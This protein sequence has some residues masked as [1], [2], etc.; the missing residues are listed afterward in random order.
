M[1]ISI[2]LIVNLYTIAQFC[3]QRFLWN[4]IRTKCCASGP[5]ATTISLL[6]PGSIKISLRRLA[7]LMYSYAPAT[8]AATDVEV[9]DP[10][11]TSHSAKKTGPPNVKRIP[12]CPHV[13][14]VLAP[15]FAPA[16]ARWL[17][18]SAANSCRTLTWTSL[19]L[20]AYFTRAWIRW[21][22][23]YGEKRRRRK[24]KMVVPDNLM[25]K[26]RLVHVGFAALR[27]C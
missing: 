22:K 8:S 18:R 13:A 6:I 1:R 27:Y 24:K 15:S 14:S 3:D 12:R 5:T 9:V 19:P 20:V 7:G 2:Q 4:F 21:W 25:T 17:T 26:N 10:K 16:R 11:N 23:R